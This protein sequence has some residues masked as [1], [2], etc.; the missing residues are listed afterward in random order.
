M[1]RKEL[2]G[3]CRYYK[4]EK[5]NPFDIS[6]S[7]YIWDIENKWV[8]ELMINNGVGQYLSSTLNHYISAGFKDFEKYDDTPITLKSML[9]SI[10]ERWNEGM[11]SYE[12]FSEFYDK[13]K[14]NSI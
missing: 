6:P 5:K 8:D 2:I 1:T 7:W 3:F 9:L 12:D 10:L 13:W 11:V 14:N 4:G